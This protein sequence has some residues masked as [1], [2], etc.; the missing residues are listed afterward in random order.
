[1][2]SLKSYLLRA[3]M[4]SLVVGVLLIPASTAAAAEPCSEIT[5]EGTFGEKAEKQRL[6][7]TLFT[8]L[9]AKGQ[10]L[11]FTWEGG[12]QHFSLK[13]PESATCVITTRG[14]NFRGHGE[15]TVNG[16]PEFIINYQIRINTEEEVTFIVKIFNEKSKEIVA[17]FTDEGLE[18]STEA[19]A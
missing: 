10:K 6:K 8:D 15:G 17:E 9:T 16:V 3:G 5:G 2:G 18:G 14:S 19:V 13:E 4:A 1:M 11:S 12:R 7:N